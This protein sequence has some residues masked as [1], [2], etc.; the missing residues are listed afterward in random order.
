VSQSRKG[1]LVE[2]LINVAI[3]FAINFTANALIFPLFGWHIDAR[4]N[5]LL[6]FIYTL[7]SIV[8][9]YCIRRCFNARIQRFAARV[10]A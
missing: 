5:L 4:A 9:S 10:S 6:G 2:A 8:R 3:G 7:I 1:S